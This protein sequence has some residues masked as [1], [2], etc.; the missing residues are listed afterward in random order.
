[1]WS[2]D[3]ALVQHLTEGMRL[4]ELK[5]IHADSSH[6]LIEHLYRLWRSHQLIVKRDWGDDTAS[7]Q[8]LAY[9]NSLCFIPTDYLQLR[10]QQAEQSISIA[11]W[12]VNSIRT[13]MPLV[14]SWLAAQQ[15]DIVCLQETKVEDHLYPAYE[16]NLAGY[17]VV[18][19]GQKTYNG[20]AI[21]SRHPMEDVKYGF[22]NGYD[23]DNKRL[24]AATVLGIR[25]LNV[26]VPQGNSIDSEKFAYK[27]DFLRE[28]LGELQQNYSNASPL[29]VVGDYNVA[30]DERDVFDAEAMKGQVSFHPAELQCLKQLQ[31]WGLH[32]VYRH[33]HV[34]AEK[35]T[36]WDFRTRGFERNEGLRI[37]HIWS[38]A[39]LLEIAK[40]CEIDQDN[41]AQPK[42]SD[43][44]PVIARFIT[45]KV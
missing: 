9:S 4:S 1:M 26:Y 37:D 27:L 3:S 33:F 23:S 14:R 19:C 24:I 35:Y 29:L 7:P 8:V 36:W 28:F 45:P 17:N 25:I 18:Y 41:R 40:A 39:S 16:F 44:A 32:D 2:E 22:S 34:E 5:A 31:N 30:P 10:S 21:L 42:P 43:H 13:R 20:V 15:P 6:Q 11:T 12:N 38:T